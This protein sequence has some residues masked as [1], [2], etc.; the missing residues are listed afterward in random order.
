MFSFMPWVTVVFVSATSF[1]TRPTVETR[2][3]GDC[4]LL[5]SSTSTSSSESTSRALSSGTSSPK[6]RLGITRKSLLLITELAGTV[7]IAISGGTIS[8]FTAFG[9]F[10]RWAA[11]RAGALLVSQ[12]NHVSGDL[13]VVAQ[14]FNTLIGE[15]PII[16]TPREL[17]LDQV[18]GSQRL[19]DH[20]NMEIR[21]SFQVGVLGGVSVL[22]GYHNTLCA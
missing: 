7:L 2:S 14:V 3:V 8:A 10:S 12:G 5:S 4:L 19:H 15:S 20:H 9:A 1:T 16:M 18:T 11:H 6:F 21:D 22:F 13:Q 17:L